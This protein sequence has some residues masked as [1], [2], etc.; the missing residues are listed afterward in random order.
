MVAN[1]SYLTLANAGWKNR[2]GTLGVGAEY[3]FRGNAAK[4]NVGWAF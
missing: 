4:I 1:T 2:A 3:F